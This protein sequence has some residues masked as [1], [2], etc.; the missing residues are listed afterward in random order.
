[1]LRYIL[2]IILVSL[3]LFALWLPYSL[4]KEQEEVGLDTTAI[5]SKLE[6]VLANQVEIFKQ[7]AEIKKEL[8]TIKVRAS[9]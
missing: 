3:C 6:K 4:S 8:V 9:R 7:F 1:M 2:T 5:I